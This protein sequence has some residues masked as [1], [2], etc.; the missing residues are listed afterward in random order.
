ME[1][2][3]KRYSIKCKADRIEFFD[4]IDETST[5]Y[6]IRHTQIAEGVEKVS[7]ESMTRD[8]FEMCLK[9]GYI[10]EMEAAG[11]TPA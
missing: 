11:A 5:E 8:L 6:R 10:F 9:T 4:I 3:M 7:E 1:A 2:N